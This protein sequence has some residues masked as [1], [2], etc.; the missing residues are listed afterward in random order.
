MSYKKRFIIGI[1][2]AALGAVLALI[3]LLSKPMITPHFTSGLF[4]FVIG[5][6]FLYLKMRCPHCQ[7]MIFDFKDHE[8][9]PHCGEDL[10]LKK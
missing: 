8:T 9:C 2:V 4:L 10:G 5:N 3:G 1:S 6:F 7:K